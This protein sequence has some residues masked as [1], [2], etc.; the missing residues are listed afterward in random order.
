MAKD[1]TSIPSEDFNPPIPSGSS[2]GAFETEG[3][4]AS[5]VHRIVSLFCF[6]WLRAGVKEECAL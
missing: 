6:F 2:G 1:S 4:Y 3:T 5:P